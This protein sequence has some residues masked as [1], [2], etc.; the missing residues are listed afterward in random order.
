MKVL[1][2]ASR[3]MGEHR[4]AWAAAAYVAV[5]GAAFP[6]L[7][8]LTGPAL[9]E[10]RAVL[11]VSLFL[12]FV[13]TL[14][15]VLG[16]A[17]IPGDLANRRMGFYLARPVSVATLLAG[18]FLGAWLLAVGGGLVVLLPLWALKL[19]S[20]RPW[21]GVA[22]LIALGAAG[23]VVTLLLAHV[24][25]TAWR[26]RSLWILLE[27]GAIGLFAWAFQASQLRLVQRG[28]LDALPWLVG[29]MALPVAPL[30]AGAVYLQVARGRTDLKEG[31]RV[32]SW[33]LAAGL[34]GLALGGALFT[35]WT[36]GWG[37]ATLTNFNLGPLAVKGDWMVLEGKG[38]FH[39]QAF[40]FNA[41]T[42]EAL[43]APFWGAFSRDGK[44]Y[45]W[46]DMA[47]DKVMVA[48]LSVTPARIEARVELPPVERKSVYSLAAMSPEGKMVL[49][50]R[51][52]YLDLV[53][54]E[55][56]R[57]V[58]HERPDYDFRA[59]KYLFP[60]EGLLRE[61]R[62]RTSQSRIIRELDLGSGQWTETG[63]LPGNL[64]VLSAPDGR[65]ALVADNSEFLICE[66]RTGA[67]QGRFQPGAG[68]FLS[69]PV[70]REDGT[71]AV[72]EGSA[73]RGKLRILDGS[74]RNL[75]L[76]DLGMPV[77]SAAIVIGPGTG[78]LFLNVFPPDAPS[79]LLVMDPAAGTLAT[80]STV[81]VMPRASSAPWSSLATR[82]RVGHEGGLGLVE[83][84]GG[85]R[86][87]LPRSCKPTH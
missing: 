63:L 41:A 17:M 40:L 58:W 57:S 53:D 45:V 54:L 21:P 11:A 37:P 78:K 47:G 75:W 61:V 42:G 25:S 23:A 76:L 27:L 19:P 34:A 9:G 62:S 8:G 20:S 33:V 81:S 50:L 74:G 38:R 56:R 1:V 70:F 26:S 80:L 82:L 71:L 12:G 67:V 7:K 4:L 2:L 29:G 32:L 43:E 16:A 15:A 64:R 44:R 83:A 35:Q 30:L 24:L 3:E 73:G 28:A 69:E 65:R 51:G 72:V 68:H 36:R 52:K 10:A 86:Q 85:E 60:S 55:T 5:A 18:R 31:H 39:E 66:A 87:I 48:D 84:T 6:W 59:A 46:L 77:E 79:R 13:L 22:S 49:L 14:S